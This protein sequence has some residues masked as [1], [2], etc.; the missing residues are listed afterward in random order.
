MQASSVP[1]MKEALVYVQLLTIED[2]QLT[3]DNV[4]IIY[5]DFLMSE[6]GID[7]PLHNLSLDQVL[8]SPPIVQ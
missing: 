4:P 7:A 8:S 1:Y 3:K 5:H 6:T 2:V